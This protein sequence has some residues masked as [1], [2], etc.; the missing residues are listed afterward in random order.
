MAETDAYARSQEEGA[1]L[2][3]LGALL[4]VKASGENTNGA[5]ALLELQQ[6]PGT[7]PPPHI[8]HQEDE[9]FYILEGELAVTCGDQTFRAAPGAFV[10]LPRGVLH[11]YT[12]VGSQPLRVPVLTVPAGFE[13]FCAEMGEP[14]P[15]RSL[16]P[17]GPPDMEKLLALARKYGVEIKL[18]AQE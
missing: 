9:A 8:H 15:T 3:M 11:A 10:F 17:G 2:W 12:I 14:A 7:E 16:P 6:P 1:A 13:K 5:F 4:T 18:P